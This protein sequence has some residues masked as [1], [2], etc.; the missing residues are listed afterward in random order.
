MICGVLVV[1][2]IFRRIFGENTADCS[3]TPR[4]DGLKLVVAGDFAGCSDQFEDVID[5]PHGQEETR[6]KEV[7]QEEVRQPEE[8]E[9]Q[10]KTNS[11]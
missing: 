1:S 11:A 6:Q 4:T 7:R 9:P 10:E 5:S 8:D 2:C 3:E